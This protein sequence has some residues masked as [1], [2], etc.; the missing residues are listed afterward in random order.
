MGGALIVVLPSLFVAAVPLTMEPAFQ[1]R[2][3]GMAE[4]KGHRQDPVE[5]RSGIRGDMT[6][7]TVDRL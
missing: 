2:N 5:G 1:Q 6:A 7:K 3:I 4:A